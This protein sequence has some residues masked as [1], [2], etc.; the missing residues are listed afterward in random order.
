LVS[1]LI[2]QLFGSCLVAIFPIEY[3]V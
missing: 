1:Q 2:E 3:L